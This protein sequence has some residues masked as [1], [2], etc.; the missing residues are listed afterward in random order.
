M[1]D[2]RASAPTC[3]LFRINSNRPS[4]S[5]TIDNT[6]GGHRC[7][8]DDSDIWLFLSH[9]RATP[10]R[11]STWFGNFRSFSEQLENDV[12]ARDEGWAHRVISRCCMTSEGQRISPQAQAATYGCES[13]RCI[14]DQQR[15][16]STTV[17]VTAKTA[18][19]APR[20]S[21]LLRWVLLLIC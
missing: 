6:T 15:C 4:S 18:R 12:M 11:H 3:S 17:A 1:I 14:L 10:M 8:A 19:T 13:S 7:Q 5:C 9:F 21:A 2:T 20:S 16:C